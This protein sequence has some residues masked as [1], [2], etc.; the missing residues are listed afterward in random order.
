MAEHDN[1][2][3]QERPAT[4]FGESQTV[5]HWLEGL[6]DGESLAAQELWNRY[7]ASLIPI[8]QARLAGLAR[9]R[10]AEDIALS[11]MKSMMI[12]IQ[13]N[14]FPQ[15]TDRDELWPLLV[16]ITARKAV[17]EQRRQ[18][19][20]RRSAKRECR[21]EDVQEYIGSQPTSEFAVEV[22][23]E[24][25]RL[26]GIL[27]DDDLKRIVELKLGGFTNDEIA[28]ELACT[29]RT[30]TRKLTRIRQEWSVASGLPFEAEHGRP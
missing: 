10:S 4:R 22:A 5:T 27:Q 12:G 19:A 15:L 2:A 26:A 20:D 1:P 8:A 21:F 11:A 9:D 3:D 16:T 7:F 18:L 17:S 29:S 30:V 23:D 25:E 24:L 28:A 13:A 14:R 6:R